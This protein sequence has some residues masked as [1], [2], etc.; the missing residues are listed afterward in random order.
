MQAQTLR[1]K[2]DFLARNL[3]W[4]WQPELGQI[5]RDLDPK[6]WRAVDHNPV[7]LLKRLDDA[8][9]ED[10]SET[11]SLQSRILQGVRRLAAYLSQRDTWATWNAGLLNVR[12]VAYFSLEFGIHECLP[13]YSGGLGV[14]AG[15]HIKSSSDLG[16][17]VMG[18]GILYTKGYFRQSLDEAGWQQE[19]YTEVEIENLPIERVNKEDGS[20]LTVEFLSGTDRVAVAVWRVH[21][22]RCELLLLDTDIEGNPEPY[23]DLTHRLY[24]GDNT[25]RIRQE[26][27]LG[28]GGVR[29]IE[30]LGITPGVY[31]LNE[32]HSAFALLEAIRLRMV[33]NGLD[34]RRCA[35]RGQPASV[36]TT[37]TPVPAG[38]DRFP[39][40]LVEEHLGWLREE[41]GIGADEFLA[42]GRV[43]PQDEDETFCMT[44]LALKLANRTNGVSALHGEVSRRMWQE[45]WPHR[46]LNDVPIGH[47]TNG[48]PHPLVD[49]AGPHPVLRAPHRA[50]NGPRSSPTPTPGER[51]REVDHGEVW[52][53]RQ[54]SKSKLVNFVRRRVAAQDAAR[55]VPAEEA[56]QKVA[57]LLDENVLTI[58]FARR[59]ATYK[60]ATLLLRDRERLGRLLTDPERPVQILI[61]GKA[62][63]R[64]EFGKHLI[65]DW[66]RLQNEDALRRPGGLRR[67]LRHRRRPAPRAG[68]GRLA[69]QPPQARGGLRHQRHEGRD[70]RRP[71][72]LGLRRLVGRGLR[73]P[74]RL[75][76]RSARPPHA[77]PRSRISG[78]GR[79]S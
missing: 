56:A 19:S 11:L 51:L 55:G 42:L 5:F 18:I 58:G 21:V 67:E 41:L 10:R 7:A 74:Q 28:I 24:W 25:T 35:A 37:H 62:H 60:R 34:L 13:L 44:V 15:D 40:A 17:P 70:Q 78:T 2:L 79:P 71:E 38:H 1:S 36:F 30:A 69:Q 63:P 50:P 61:A 9:L 48:D 66:A 77:T 46:N 32:G 20:P 3:Y 8:T 49:G 57:K 75:R 47:I 76:H 65:Q 12:P 16:L 52:E 39:A 26:M 73:R 27:V 14:L 53:T 33:E 29:V 4:T 31:H 64:D 22:G 23:R 68:R 6:L 43:D 72:S 45:L 59:F 54:V